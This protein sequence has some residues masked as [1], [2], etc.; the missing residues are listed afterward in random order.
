MAQGA[1]FRSS[2]SLEGGTEVETKLQAIGKAGE[3]AFRK[4]ERASGT[5]GAA[6]AKFRGSGEQA[7]GS[8]ERA[9]RR[10]ELGI[11]RVGGE[12][13]R[14]TQKMQ[15]FADLTGGLTGGLAALFAFEGALRFKQ[16]I[17]SLIEPF[18]NLRKTAAAF[19][20]D[21][22]TITAL[23]GAMQAAGLQSS[24][25]AGVFSKFGTVLSDAQKNVATLNNNLFPTISVLKGA[26]GAAASAA[27][28]VTTFRGAM[29]DGAVGAENLAQ[30][31]R[32]D[33]IENLNATGN[34]FER[35]GI[36]FPK[37]TT[38]AKAMEIVAAKVAQLGKNIQ[39]V[40]LRELAAAFN[41]D[42][43]QKFANLLDVINKKQ[44]SGLKADAANL[45]PTAED[46]AR[47]EA[48]DAAS[49][50][51]G[52]TWT[53]L[54]QNFTLAVA[55]FAQ[56]ELTGAI[57]FIKGL[58]VEFGRIGAA[59]TEAWAVARDSFVNAGLLA[60]NDEELAKLR[61]SWES[62]GAFFTDTVGP[63]VTEVWAAIVTGMSDKLNEWL[64]G[65]T[66]IMTSFTSLIETAGG[67]IRDRLGAA[68]DFIGE[69]IKGIASA[70][71]SLIGGAAAAGATAGAGAFAGGGIIRGRGG[72]TD[73]NIPAWLS[74][75]EAVTRARAV[76]YYGP[77]LFHALNRMAI[78]RGL[79]AD[80]LAGLRG[81]SMGGLV[82]GL[83]APIVAHGMPRF[84]LGGIV[85]APAATH[86]NRT[87]INLQLGG[88][89]FPV[90]A[91]DDI[92]D[93]LVRRVRRRNMVRAGR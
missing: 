70:L 10:V 52:N 81:F 83:S 23:G 87:P 89:T 64:I 4:I 39:A 37:F 88:E 47:I 24:D 8:V 21:P 44:F 9:H 78:P 82:D 54:K 31:M 63:L 79:L 72:P 25:A 73:D 76:A 2:I 32:G 57:N 42:D 86:S 7:A 41:I 28:D 85:A 11:F 56:L 55:P 27:S 1:G 67:F 6:F 84:A 38:E 40:D 29:K 80:L 68:L 3:D 19:K 93:A 53:T 59:A 60:R 48:F 33:V 22:G 17:S 14:T 51:L 71:A 49:A 16:V 69:K 26:G 5:S 36:K 18:E 75:G 45:P 13:T 43:I 92:A 50:K 20:V 66:D 34:V 61:A 35:L 77:D 74:A 15:I 62:L 90:F 30:V 58:G 46:F 91:D 65:A 12:L